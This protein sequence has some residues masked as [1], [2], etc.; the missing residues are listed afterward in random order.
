M[1]GNLWRIQP[2]LLQWRLWQVGESC[3]LHL[4]RDATLITFKARPARQRHELQVRCNFVW[5]QR[6]M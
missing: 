5:S 3:F 1:R 2:A 4:H 6:N